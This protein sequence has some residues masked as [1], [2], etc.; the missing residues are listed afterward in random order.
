LADNR[1]TFAGDADDAVKE[2]TETLRAWFAKGQRAVL[3]VNQNN[4]KVC[5][6]RGDNI[7]EKL[8]G[9]LSH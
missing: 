5:I 2:A 7:E 9:L 6:R 3:A 8:A 4:D 1:K